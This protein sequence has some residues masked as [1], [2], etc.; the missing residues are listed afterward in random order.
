MVAFCA[1]SMSSK[2]SHDKMAYRPNS[3]RKCFK[4]TKLWGPKRNIGVNIIDKKIVS[5]S[6]AVEAVV[7]IVRSIAQGINRLFVMQ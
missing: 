6:L 1:R 7:D 4:D 2:V 5:E 3:S